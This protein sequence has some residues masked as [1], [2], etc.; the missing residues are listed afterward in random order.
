[1][2]ARK[3]SPRDKTRFWIDNFQKIQKLYFLRFLKTIQMAI[4]SQIDDQLWFQNHFCKSTNLT[5]FMCLTRNWTRFWTTTV[6]SFFFVRLHSAVSRRHIKFDTRACRTSFFI[7]LFFSW[8]P[9]FRHKSIRFRVN[10]PISRRRRLRNRIWKQQQN[11]SEHR[12]EFYKLW[13]WAK[14][15]SEFA[16]EIKSNLGRFAA[17][18][19]WNERTFCHELS[20]TKI[21]FS[22]LKWFN[23]CIYPF[24]TV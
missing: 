13:I 5:R 15:E 21:H 12:L 3:G 6:S 9:I 10:S 20:K 1:M 22:S 16:D 23:C 8:S 19:F 24:I 2:P 7:I 4:W 17:R 18:R 11:R 14:L